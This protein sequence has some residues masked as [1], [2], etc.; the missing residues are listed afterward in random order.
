MIDA[1]IQRVRFTNWHGITLR[2]EKIGPGGILLE[3]GNGTGKT[4]FVSGL[5]ACLTGK[6][7]D[8]TAVRVGAEEAEL[9]VDLTHATVRRVLKA[10]GSGGVK[11]TLE[12]GTTASSPQA[13]LNDLFGIAPLDPVDLF[14]EKDP[15]KRRAKVL[16][17]MPI[18]VTP[19]ILEQW[20]PPG[21]KVTAKECEGHGLDVIE[22]LRKA[23]YERRTE[24][25]RVLK[26]A[27]TAHT[28]AALKLATTLG[29]LGEGDVR[30][31]EAVAADLK[32][33]ERK[34]MG[35]ENMV[36]Q[37]KARASHNAKT[38][39][40][41]KALRDQAQTHLADAQKAAPEAGKLDALAEE[42]A[43]LSESIETWE[44]AIAKLQAQIAEIEKD[45]QDDMKAR[46][47]VDQQIDAL[48]KAEVEAERL[49]NL[50]AEKGAQAEDLEA[51]IAATEPPS[52]E[53]I[54]RVGA[55]VEE[56]K[57]ELARSAKLALVSDA[58]AA[59]AKAKAEH[60]AAQAAQAALDKSEKALKDEAPTALLA[61]SGGV[62]GLTVEGETIRMD[63]IALD[64]LSGAEQLRFAVDIA[65]RLNTAKGSKL[66]IID[67]L[68]AVAPDRREEFLAYCKADG[69]QV[70]A[71]CVGTGPAIAK[72]I[73]GGR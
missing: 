31:P 15:K 19:A 40:R 70:I 66:L 48:A 53:E 17:A 10:N 57:K 21:E 16:A 46:V 49:T 37:A 1:T 25:N 29:D 28:T 54:A 33:V 39:D 38:R 35:L 3:G 24:A 67:K 18:A 9:L 50:S 63:G 56:L 61:A 42:R 59:E 73:G 22:R 12:D 72:P 45:R 5:R 65:K 20:L 26:A 34:Q 11:V 13:W 62:P 44:G 4:G 58:K 51:T 60:E 64:M 30:E 6:G 55:R 2:E 52:E 43:K 8:E 32:L 36:E 23:V 14:E 71:T 68:E 7:V 27:K 41:V 47:L 69:F